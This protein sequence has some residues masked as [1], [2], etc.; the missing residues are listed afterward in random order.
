M[1]KQ[2]EN[3]DEP[4]HKTSENVTKTTGSGLIC[5]IL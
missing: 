3:N 4:S 2:V 1:I 5:E